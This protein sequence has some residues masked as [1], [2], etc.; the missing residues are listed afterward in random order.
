MATAAEAAAALSINFPNCRL[1]LA[2]V[3]IFKM[4]QTEED[5]LSL[6]WKYPLLRTIVRPKSGF[7][8]VMKLL[9][10]RRRRNLKNPPDSKTIINYS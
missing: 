3:A 9:W 1:L 4:Y 5:F 7:R 2:N 6:D 10:N 8:C